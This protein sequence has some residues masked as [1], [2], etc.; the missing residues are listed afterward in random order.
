[1]LSPQKSELVPLNE[2]GHHV[3]DGAL[4]HLA[5]STLA[6]FITQGGVFFEPKDEAFLHIVN[7]AREE[8]GWRV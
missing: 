5:E 3:A 2:V 8:V 1:L 7:Q 6:H 4:A